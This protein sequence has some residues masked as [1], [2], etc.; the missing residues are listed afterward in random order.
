[1]PL[2]WLTF[3]ALKRSAGLGAWRGGRDGLESSAGKGVEECL[4]DDRQQGKLPTLIPLSSDGTD[5]SHLAGE[6]QVEHSSESP[7][8]V[9][10]DCFTSRFETALRRRICF[11][12]VEG[13]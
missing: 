5:F 1:M 2:T 13:V 3:P 7:E 4:A 10:A 12:S 6:T 9:C 11:C 8:I